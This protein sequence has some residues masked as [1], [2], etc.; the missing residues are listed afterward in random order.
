MEQEK[1]NTV[2]QE[3]GDLEP[4][5]M[6]RREKEAKEIGFLVMYLTN[7]E[8]YLLPALAYVLR[9]NQNLAALIMSNVDNIGAKISIFY[10]VVELRSS[11]TFGSKIILTKPKVI[12]AI[13]F[14]NAIAHS[15]F[16]T[17]KSFRPS[18]ISEELRGEEDTLILI[19]NAIST[20]RG[21]LSVQKITPF[22]SKKSC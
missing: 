7:L 16:G 17:Y 11:T 14:R 22:D 2:E 20:R 1:S 21:K 9:R 3:N 15:H 6:L 10:G 5:N 12:K 4:G 8:F 13:A 19:Q 18:K